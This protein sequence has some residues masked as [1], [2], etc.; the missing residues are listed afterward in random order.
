MRAAVTDEVVAAAAGEKPLKSE[1]WTWQRGE[2]NPRSRWRRKPSRVCETP[3]TERSR[4]LGCPAD[5]DSTEDAAK[6][7]ETPGKAPDIRSGRL[8]SVL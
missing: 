3:R 8:E 4:A 5:V 7:T 6:R 1:S 2:I